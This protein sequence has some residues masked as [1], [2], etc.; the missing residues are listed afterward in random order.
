VFL[1]KALTR[2][3]QLTLAQRSLQDT[4]ITFEVLDVAVVPLLRLS[5]RL[6]SILDNTLESV[7]SDY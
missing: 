6:D 2:D 3:N 4:N 1:E 5:S 7:C